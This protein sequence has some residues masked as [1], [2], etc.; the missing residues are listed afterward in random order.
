MRNK[1]LIFSL[2][3]ISFLSFQYYY[4]KTYT[5]F[6]PEFVLPSFPSGTFEMKDVK[7][8]ELIVFIT[9]QNNRIFSFNY[10]EFLMGLPEYTRINSFRNIYEKSGKNID[11]PKLLKWY[12]NKGKELVKDEVKTITLTKK[13]W[14]NDLSSFELKRK[15]ISENDVFEIKL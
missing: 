3:W 4:S 15:L 14:S 6:F 2:F 9:D 13:I 8:E 11:N 10:H 5:R 1:Y 7:I 12:K